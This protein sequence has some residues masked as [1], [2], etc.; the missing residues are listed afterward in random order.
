M[1]ICTSELIP[2]TKHEAGFTYK[3]TI[4]TGMRGYGRLNVACLKPNSDATE[5]SQ[6]TDLSASECR[7]LANMLLATASLLDGDN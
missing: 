3:I 7:A 4:E 2:L 1:S 5:N 6:G